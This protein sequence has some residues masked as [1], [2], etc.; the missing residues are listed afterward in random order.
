MTEDASRERDSFSSPPPPPLL[1]VSVLGVGL[2]G[3]S[4]VRRLYATTGHRVVL[5]NRTRAKAERLLHD[6]ISQEERAEPPQPHE[7][8]LSLAATAEEAI[9]RSDC[10]LSMLFDHQANKEVLYSA[11]LH[12]NTNHNERGGGGKKE[13][14]RKWIV[15]LTDM[16]PKQSLSLA[17]D[18]SSLA[19]G[20]YVYVEAPL[21]ASQTD[22]L[23]GTARVFLSYLPSSC[24]CS[25]SSC[26][27]SSSSSSSSSCSSCSS[28][29]SSSS[30]SS[31]AA[32]AASGGA[33]D[34]E[35]VRELLKCFGKCR[36]VGNVPKANLCKLALL[37]MPLMQ[38]LATAISLGSPSSALL[39]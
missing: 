39:S 6:L 13:E 10:V 36:A 35:E 22:V 16:S 11:L 24:P 8:R 26:S 17:Q 1:T 31:S 34:V 33:C 9:Q 20:K 2:M 25:S 37:V 32:A 3:A 28:S 18:I 14:R 38:L 12:L 30:S 4:L 23:N 21:L 29:C 19:H 5:F 15:V 27:C 7:A